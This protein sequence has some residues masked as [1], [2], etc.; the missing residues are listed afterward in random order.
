M[1]FLFLFILSC[2]LPLSFILFLSQGNTYNDTVIWDHG[3][4]G[5]NQIVAVGDTGLET[6]SCFWKDPSHVMKYKQSQP[7]HRKIHLYHDFQDRTD[8][9]RGHGSHVATSVCGSVQT[10]T[11]EIAAYQGMAPAARISFF[12]FKR[13]GNYP[14]VIPNDIFQDYYNVA[15]TIGDSDICSNSWGAETWGGYDSDARETDRFA[16]TFP[17]FL[18]IYA[19]GNSGQQGQYSVVSPCVGKNV[20][21]V[22]ATR[23]AAESWAELGY[24]SAIQVVEPSDLSGI[25]RASIADFGAKYGMMPRMDS[26]ELVVS[27]PVFFPLRLS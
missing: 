10:A 3:L 6:N 19:A 2:L 8:D 4:K 23:N 25:H 21:C 14:L 22:G 15:R 7:D 17:N 11:G 5:E 18:P 12:D 9:P 20:L 27:S 26:H 1:Y 13:T 24:T 16:A